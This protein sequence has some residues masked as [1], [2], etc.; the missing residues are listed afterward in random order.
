MINFDN[1]YN[2]AEFSKMDR[3]SGIGGSDIAAILGLSKWKTPLDVYNLKVGNTK[4]EEQTVA[5]ARGKAL[6]PFLLDLV[7]DKE[8]WDDCNCLNKTTFISKEKPWRYFTP[9]DFLGTDWIIELKTSHFSRK[10]EYG[11][12][13]TDKIPVEYLLQAHYY[14]AMAPYIEGVDLFVLFGDE[15]LFDVLSKTCGGAGNCLDVDYDF[16]H[17][18]VLRNKEISEKILAAIDE[19][20][21]CVQNKTPP[22]WTTR[23]DILSI[24]PFA[25]QDKK[26]IADENLVSLIQNAS[27]L[28]EEI[29]KDELLYSKTIDK[30]LGSVGDCETVVDE[31]GNELATW[32][33]V[34]SQRVNLEL[35]REERPA[36]YHEFM[37]E[38]NYRRFCLKKSGR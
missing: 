36:I 8:D 23:D 3:A 18:V 38:N 7:I 2:T 10:K 6:E 12:E 22:M 32:K 20:W 24:S 1:T 37:E 31:N 35:L 17:Y 27:D 14:L 15:V 25:T 11:E 13:Y 30:I 34:K 29:R 19:F 9:D 33:N 21:T 28:K 5:M 26:L 16:R 4:P